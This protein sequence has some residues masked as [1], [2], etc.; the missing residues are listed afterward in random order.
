MNYKVRASDYSHCMYYPQIL[1][2]A[3][4]RSLENKQTNK[5]RSL[6]SEG[7]NRIA[8]PVVLT[9]VNISLKFL[10]EYICINMISAWSSLN[11]I[12]NYW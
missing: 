1:A 7:R 10:L 11:F 8:I 3:T 2:W 4:F 12:W 6:H 9:V 5:Q